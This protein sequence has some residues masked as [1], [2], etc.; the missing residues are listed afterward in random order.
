VYEEAHG[1]D[2]LGIILMVEGLLGL[3]A[4]VLFW[5]G[6]S[7]WN[8]R[9]TAHGNFGAE[10][11][12]AVLGQGGPRTPT[13]SRPTGFAPGRSDLLCRPGL[14]SMRARLACGLAFPGDPARGVRLK[15]MSVVYWY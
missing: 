2:R 14:S 12:W 3:F 1:W 5:S 11:R 9:R 8:R 10:G 4:A 7:P 13:A 6:F 15:V